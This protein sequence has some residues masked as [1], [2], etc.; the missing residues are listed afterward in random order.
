MCYGAITG[1]IGGV[2][3]W[4][5]GYLMSGV[6]LEMFIEFFQFPETM[7]VEQ[8]VSPM[9]F[10]FSLVIAT[11]G[12]LLGAFMGAVKI[13]GLSPSE[14]MRPE[15]PKPVKN[16]IIGKIVILKYL[17]TSRGFM[18]LRGIARNPVRSSFVVLGV[19]FSFAILA[20]FGSMSDLV[21]AMIYSQFTDIRLYNARVT[22]NR[23]IHYDHAIESAFAIPHITQAEGLLELPATLRNRHLQEGTVLTGVPANS[24][25][26]RVFDTNTGRVYAPT[27]EGLIITNGLAVSLNARA[28]DILYIDSHF[29]DNDIAVPITRVIEQNIGSGAF[30]ELTALSA[31]FDQP[32]IATAIIFNS[33]NLPFVNEYFRESRYAATFEDKDSTLQKYLDM[34]EPFSAMFMVMNL[35]GVAV[36]FAIIYNTATISLSERKREYATLRVLGMTVDEVCEIM[37]FE[38]W[39]LSIIGMLLGI[40]MASMIGSAVNSMMDITMISMPSTLP[41][42]AYVTGVVGCIVAIMLSNWSAKRKIQKF[43]MVEVLKER[44]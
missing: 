20:F 27:T 30:M 22:L 38:Y 35:M 18:A 40:P 12:G 17:L 14:A 31:I 28:G 10:V 13:L 4:G 19:T 36:A 26:F 2:V 11:A 8:A 34:M 44:E 9:Y 37:R 42:A 15:S 23:P 7:L 43:D 21:D 6:Y 1:V 25:L 3:G 5:Y 16:N 33:D 32:A 24:E 41:T 39:L 29:M